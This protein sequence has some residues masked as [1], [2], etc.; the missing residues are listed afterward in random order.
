MVLARL[1]VMERS[2][3][4][5]FCWRISRIDR[6]RL[7]RF[8]HPVS[9]VV[10]KK[11][12]EI[13]MKRFIALLLSFLLIF[14]VMPSVSAAE[15]VPTSVINVL[16]E[17]GAQ[18]PK[19]VRQT[20]SANLYDN[21]VDN[22]ATAIEFSNTSYAFLDGNGKIVRIKRVDEIRTRK[23][24]RSASASRFESIDSLKTYIEQNLIGEGYALVDEYYFSEDVLSLRYEKI[25]FS[26]A[27][28]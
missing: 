22:P 5:R 4:N 16:Q 10:I 2:Y 8:F 7:V 20:R 27:V 26:D 19:V 28:D 21:L 24:V 23:N 1:P 25:L 13:I 9:K 18:N 6:N 17:L 15:E 3:Q 12:R 11:W 14:C